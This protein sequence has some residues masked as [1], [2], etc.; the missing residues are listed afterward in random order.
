MEVL[1]IQLNISMKKMTQPGI[2]FALTFAMLLILSG[3]G[4]SQTGMPEILN[5]GTFNEQM[6]YI[7]ER[8]RIYENYRAIREDMFQKIRGNAIDTLA[9]AKMEIN[10]L[11]DITLNLNYKI[12]SLIASLE[13]TKTN[14]DEMTST[15]NS[16]RLLG[17][18][19]NKFVYNS[20]MWIV[21]AGLLCALVIGFIAFKRNMVITGQTKKEI[22]ELK[23]EF[24]DYR[25][26]AREAREKMSMEHFNEIRRLK[27]G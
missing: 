23:D 4:I 19:V 15:K 18:E 16:I 27:G 21:V 1:H 8:T 3:T 14:L 13:T 20:I 17:M 22:E 10:G 11:E 5:N 12:D 25:K 7:Q 2:R 6:D 24:E 26:A 9:K